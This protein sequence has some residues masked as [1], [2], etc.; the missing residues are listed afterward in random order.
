MDLKRH[1]EPLSKINGYL[2]SGVF[3]P[4]GELLEGNSMISG[5]HHELAGA[6]VNDTL[7]HAQEMINSIGMGHSNFLQI[8]SDLGIVLTRC[9]NNKQNKHFHTVLYLR[10]DGNVAM[11]KLMLQKAVDA[12][13]NEF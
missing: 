4:T 2:G 9:F 11:A 8:D 10:K 12:L 1:I 7:L 6:A 13:T 5:I 3:T